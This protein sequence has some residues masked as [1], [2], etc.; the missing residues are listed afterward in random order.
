MGGNR[1][2]L[3]KYQRTVIMPSLDRLLIVLPD[4]PYEIFCDLVITYM[5][6]SYLCP[7][8]VH[9]ATQF[10]PYFHPCSL[11]VLSVPCQFVQVV[12]INFIVSEDSNVKIYL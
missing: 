7:I 5:C 11:L 3:Q 8:F 1:A 4:K 10:T 6:P 9:V 12:S 2:R